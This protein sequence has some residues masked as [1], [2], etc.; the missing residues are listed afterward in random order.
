MSEYLI[1]NFGGPRN[2]EEIS[3][4]LQELLCDR[5]VI[6]T[7]YP[8]F[9]H[10][11]LFCWVAKKRAKKIAPDYEKIGGR[12]PLF[13]DTEAIAQELASRLGATVH[14]FHRYLPSTHSSFLQK[15]ESSCAEEIRV[16]PLFPQFSFATT[17]SIARFFSHHLS[18]SCQK[19]LSWI[20]SYP[21][22]PAYVAA[23]QRCIREHLQKEKLKEEECV[24]LF[25][26]HGLPQ[27]FIETGD[28][29]QSECVLSYEEIRRA[30]PQALTRLSYQSQ[31]GRDEWIRPSTLEVCEE[32]LSWHDGRP[33]VVIIPLSFTSD[34]IETL[35]EIEE[36]YLPPIRKRG[37]KAYRC[38]ALNLESYWLTA[39]T[40]L[41]QKESLFSKNHSLVKII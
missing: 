30:F 18:P 6:R 23:F 25:S 36:Q 32:V 24:L 10:K 17:G 15:I 31:F 28:P 20:R 3:P 41:L 39:L 22:H 33:H 7:R 9:L 16:L 29:Y 37:L 34:H 11:T 27:A 14:T 38:P 19:K 1:V 5:D 12:S 13:F 8:Q 40:D 21:T 35:F 4:F 2:L 26:A